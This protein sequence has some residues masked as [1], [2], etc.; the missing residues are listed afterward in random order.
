MGQEW[1]LTSQKISAIVR[2]SHGTR[3]DTSLL[4]HHHHHHHRHLEN[5]IPEHQTFLIRMKTSFS[6]AVLSSILASSPWPGCAVLLEMAP[7]DHHHHSQHTR[8]HTMTL[9][10]CCSTQDEHIP[11][12]TLTKRKKSQSVAWWPVAVIGGPYEQ[13]GSHI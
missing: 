4:H 3:S 11:A 2:R 10:V 7:S 1:Q 8:H 5:L 12:V 6:A 9:S 13:R